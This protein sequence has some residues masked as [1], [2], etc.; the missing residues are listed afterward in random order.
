MKQHTRF[1]RCGGTV[2]HVE[3][4]GTSASRAYRHPVKGLSYVIM[5][6][7]I[8]DGITAIARGTSCGD[9]T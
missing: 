4:A 1:M 3:G 6:S 8:P 7:G 9:S 2:C 5:H